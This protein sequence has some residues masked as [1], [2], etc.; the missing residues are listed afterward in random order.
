MIMA[1][2]SFT[3]AQQD[4]IDAQGGSVLVS[5][6]AGSGKT[7]VL[8]QRV[9]KLLTDKAKPVSADRLLIVTFTKAAAEEMKSRIAA[10][11]DD[12]LLVEPSNTALRRQQLL[13]ANADICTIDSFCSR[14]IRD[15]F[16]MLD[17]DRDFRVFSEGEAAVLRHR[18]ISEV[19]EESYASKDEG[20]LFLAELLSSSRSDKSMEN[21]LLSVYD[22][23]SSHPFPFLWLDSV[24][25]YYDPTVEVQDTIYAKKAFE[26]LRTAAGD[27][28]SL[29]S[30]AREVIEGNQAFCTDKPTCGQ[31]NLENL[32]RFLQ[33]LKK[34]LEE[35]SWDGVSACISGFC[36][37][38][39]LK[40]RSKSLPVS[41]SE[42]VIVRNCFDNIS[43]I[44]NNSLLPI[45]GTS[46]QAYK[47]S[48]KKLYP[49]VLALCNVIKRF[50]KAYFEAKTERGV[51]DFAD[52]EHLL[53]KLLVTHDK[54]GNMHKTDF[55]KTLSSGY[56][57][58]MV[59]EYQDTNET[60]ETIF[61][62]ISDNENNLFVVG[63]V[64]QSIYRFRE[65]MPEIFKNRR[66]ASLP[67][68]RKMP[69]FPAK[70][71]LDKN[72]R[73]REGIIDSVNFVFHSI[74]SERV[75]EI[76]YN[77]DEKLTTGASYPESSEPSMEL[78]LLD[79]FAMGES[80]KGDE[81][82]SVLEAGFI[83]QL[84]RKK[85]DEGLT[86]YDRG[87]LR[88][89][90]YG[91]F[92][93][94]MRYTSTHARAYSDILNK[95]GIPAYID[96]PYSLFGCFEVNILL[97]LLKTVDNPMQDIPM[98]SVLLCPVFGFEPDDLTDL[99][100]LFI[101]KFILSRIRAC[102]IAHEKNEPQ[103]V[104]SVL[105][106]KCR[107]FSKI[108]SE[109][110]KLS[111][112]M[113]P[114]GLLEKFFE[115]TGFI[116]MMNASDN[117]EIRVRNIRKLMS[118]VRDY[119]KSGKRSL[120][121]LVRHINYLEENGTNISAGDTVPTNSVR[122]MSVHHSK[123][124]EFPVCILAGLDAKGNN[125]S[126]EISCHAELGFGMKTAE[127]SSLLKFN[128]VQRNVISLCK[129]SEDISEAMRVLYVAMTR[130]KEKLIPVVSYN[131]RSKD[132]LK[133]KLKKLAS[134]IMLRDG[135]IS[136]FSVSASA[137][138][139]DW[140]MLCALVHPSMEELRAL[141]GSTGL[142]TLPSAANWSFE[143]V[144]SIESSE[145]EKKLS[146]KSCPPDVGLLDL[147][148]K[149]FNEK[150]PDTLR[151]VIP[152]KVSASALVHSE[153]AGY[154]I[155]VSRPAFTRKEEM[156]GSERGTAMHRFLQYADLFHAGSEPTAE[157]ELLVQAGYLTEEQA[158]SIRD[159][160]IVAFVNSGLF[161]HYRNAESML[162]E[163]RF[164]VNIP[165]S[166]IDTSYPESESVILQGAIDCVL[167]EADGIIIVDYKTDRLSSMEEL[168]DR[169]SK[170]LQLYKM[171]AQ[172]IFERPVKACYIYSVY[173]GLYTEIKT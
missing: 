16:F 98:L 113:P 134:R 170:Q 168:S 28:D 2:M 108:L 67:Y 63:D 162:R 122:I 119:E 39:Y 24:A 11:I 79:T 131:L 85:L 44:V 169:Y 164:T 74:M 66:A 7:R 5:A 115:L 49:A 124:L 77:N 146:E 154:H 45:F 153:Q 148:K 35:R 132:G 83:A 40:P 80:S 101:G 94:L 9:I 72:F 128:T 36:G 149:R 25:Q 82:T 106:E 114:S 46:S 161:R 127:R 143:L 93:V 60:Q 26:M 47:N 91:D 130:A 103:Q 21:E 112:T 150:Y 18:I 156:S 32:E 56:D 140:I 99:K 75:G 126:E 90:R 141:S 129:S 92:A 33:G 78:C 86:V 167:V 160:D 30:Q 110:R 13:L 37:V 142:E 3:P 172:Q 133:N 87:V 70:I 159:E 17:I 15:N 165:A 73:S 145:P 84:I 109:L 135:R 4:A 68:N 171:A 163:Y 22:K 64:K 27:I 71:I 69:A 111:V 8:V 1:E 43:D 51:L 41:E 144:S 117:G 125:S 53:L 139:A 102:L 173:N 76:E 23:C 50:D 48:A 116:P 166:M 105:I 157:K 42:A 152:S 137:S 155:A 59:D 65:A 120:T 95:N 107:Y 20:F 88:P 151:T 89:A 52:L 14:V 138:L 55:A 54:D 38:N 81:D 58:I 123:G 10:A 121:E 104:S 96:M 62:F 57:Q 29:L 12:L 118:F 100:T 6:A 97:S 61:R 31:A 147:L 34:E 19:I 158:Q 136:P